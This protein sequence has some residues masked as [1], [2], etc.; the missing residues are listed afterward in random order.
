MLLLRLLRSWLATKNNPT[1]YRPFGMALSHQKGAGALAR[2]RFPCV[3]RFPR[4]AHFRFSLVSVDR[5]RTI[6][7]DF[8]HKT[9][10]LSL[11]V[12]EALMADVTNEFPFHNYKPLTNCRT[13]NSLHNLAGRKVSRIPLCSLFGLLE[14][15]TERNQRDL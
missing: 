3:I 15:T 2:I 4:S 14:T 6:K 9:F 11:K 1:N 5:S 8:N 10:K 12:D 7:S 13:L